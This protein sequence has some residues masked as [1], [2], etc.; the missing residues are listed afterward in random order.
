MSNDDSHE[1]SVSVHLLIDESSES[2]SSPMMID[3]SHS[4]LPSDR[5]TSHTIHTTT[6]TQ[7]HAA[8]HSAHTY[9]TAQSS[10]AVSSTASP[11][12]SNRRLSPAQSSR[13]LNPPPT[14]HTS[15]S[16]S[17]HPPSSIPSTS[18]SSLTHLQQ[19]LIELSEHPRGDSSLKRSDMRSEFPRRLTVQS[20]LHQQ[21]QSNAQSPAIS[22]INTAASHKPSSTSFS[23][24]RVQFESKLPHTNTS[25]VDTSSAAM[26]PPPPLAS[27]DVFSDEDDD[28]RTNPAHLSEQQLKQALIHLYEP[29]HKK[30]PAHTQPMPPS[31]VD[32]D[33][34][35]PAAAVDVPLTQP[36]HHQNNNTISASSVVSYNVT[37][38]VTAM[39][40]STHLS[41]ALLSSSAKR[42]PVSDSRST[43]HSRGRLPHSESDNAT[44]ISPILRTTSRFRKGILLLCLVA[45]ILVG[46]TM[47]LCFHQLSQVQSSVREFRIS[48][49][50]S[51]YTS[52]LLESL[53]NGETGTRGFQITGLPSY[54]EPYNKSVE[55]VPIFL[56][57]L[58]GYVDPFAIYSL[59]H[60]IQNI[61]SQW[62]Q[63]IYDRNQ[64]NGFELS[65]NDTLQLNGKGT[66][67]D[68]R[69][70]LGELRQVESAI[71][72]DKYD[73]ANYA[74]LFMTI[75]TA[76][77]MSLIIITVCAGAY[78]GLDA[79]AKGL[80]KHNE[81]LT[82]LLKKAEE[83]TKLKSVFLASMSHEI[84]TPSQSFYIHSSVTALFFL[85]SR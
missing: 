10:I 2:R 57:E 47:G 48:E 75:S 40:P 31:P 69:V 7:T 39:K 85:L 3:D 62:Q 32:Q 70:I 46:I 23:S 34:F 20:S 65:R 76:I 13:S 51:N 43:L 44:Q 68:I 4:P 50:I 71:V 12:R 72:H 24:R 56:D 64:P 73:E 19:R 58:R 83:S 36:I 53:L 25:T 6:H 81:Q 5:V 38:L 55:T 15:S 74:I 66:M 63:T 78:I 17:S 79:D 45:V 59:E 35:S 84:R 82:V 80:R 52:S 41:P 33:L 27:E 16:T 42:L 14:T 30:S 9:A 61:S 37:P 28:M 54:L 18:I 8:Q 11:A 77:S 21:H 26:N 29:K 1:S 49:S 22:S 60:L 67:D